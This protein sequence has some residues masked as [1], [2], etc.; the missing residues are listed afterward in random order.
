[1]LKF[2]E[3]MWFAFLGVGPFEYVDTQAN[4]LFRNSCALCDNERQHRLNLQRKQSIINEISQITQLK[5]DNENTL[6][7][8]VHEIPNFNYEVTENLSLDSTEPD[9]QFRPSSVISYDRSHSPKSETFYPD[10]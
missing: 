6:G 2:F 3:K 10:N 4:I 5:V 7:S 1:M 9:V 8:I